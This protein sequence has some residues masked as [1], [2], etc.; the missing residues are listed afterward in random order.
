MTRMSDDG[1]GFAYMLS[2]RESVCRE[3]NKLDGWLVVG[4]RLAEF[5]FL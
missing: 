1:T 2:E 4:R 3:I 5:W